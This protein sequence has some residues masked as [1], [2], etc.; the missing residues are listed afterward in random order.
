MGSVPIVLH[1]ESIRPEL[2]FH[3][4][5]QELS[6][7][8]LGGKDIILNKYLRFEDHAYLPASLDKARTE[9]QRDIQEYGFSQ[10]RLVVAFSKLAQPE[11]RGGRTDQKP[12]VVIAGHP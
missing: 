7:K 2:L 12:V 11:G 10:L 1:D 8:I 4:E 9:S 5:C 3:L 6:E